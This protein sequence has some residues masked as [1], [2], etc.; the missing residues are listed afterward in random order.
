MRMI[1]LGP[2]GAG[3]VTQARLLCEALDIPQIATGDML[4][5]AVNSGSSLGIAA[6]RVMDNGGLVADDIIIG[7]VKER[8]A[9]P[10]CAK[11]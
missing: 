4:R 1:L 11:G 6:K 5:N 3:K 7:L 8:L 2:P 10:D 9:K